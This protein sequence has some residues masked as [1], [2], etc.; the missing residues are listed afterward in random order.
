LHHNIRFRQLLKLEVLLFSSFCD[1]AAH[2]QS[3]FCVPSVA[4]VRAHTKDGC[5]RVPVAPDV[6]GDLRVVPH[7]VRHGAKRASVA[8]EV[9]G[10]A[11]HAACHAAVHVPVAHDDAGDLRVVPLCVRHDAKSVSVA[12]KV[13]GAPCVEPPVARHDAECVSVAHEVTG[14]SQVG[15]HDAHL[16]AESVPVA[17]DVAGVSRAMPHDARLNAESV[18][19][20]HEA[21]GVLHV[22]PHAACHDAP[23]V[24][25]AHEPAGVEPVRVDV[26]S[27]ARADRHLFLSDLPQLVQSFATQMTKSLDACLDGLIDRM[28]SLQDRVQALEIRFLD[29]EH[30]TV[31]TLA[32]V[33]KEVSSL[34]ATLTEEPVLDPLP[35]DHNVASVSEFGHEASLANFLS[36]PRK[37]MKKYRFPRSGDSLQIDTLVSCFA[38]LP[39]RPMKKYKFLHPGIKS[40]LP[41]LSEAAKYFPHTLETSAVSCLI[42]GAACHPSFCPLCKRRGVFVAC[43]GTCVPSS[44]SATSGFCM[45]CRRL[46]YSSTD[47]ASASDIHGHVFSDCM[48]GLHRNS[49]CATNDACLH[50]SRMN[51][52]GM[53][54]D[55]DCGSCDPPFSH[56][57]P[58]VVSYSASGALDVGASGSSSSW[59]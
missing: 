33:P 59:L 11:P 14:A 38:A 31:C 3:G 32:N 45:F 17:R 29:L 22:E 43:C 13:D 56:V 21:P 35:F 1:D 24:L 58:R 25:V 47:T 37:G 44:E 7:S 28:V 4:S 2:S 42:C 40:R 51:L 5:H 19:V 27:D 16:D 12:H 54:N 39:R 41:T 8:H 26:P 18:P 53:S 46:P 50:D 30:M 36:L 20:A 52:E 23:K 34:P 57:F 9:D 48:P 10:A 15:S 49:S 6:A 55:F